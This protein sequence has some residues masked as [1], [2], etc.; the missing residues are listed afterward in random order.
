MHDLDGQAIH[1]LKVALPKVAQLPGA[2]DGAEVAPGLQDQ[3]PTR[4]AVPARLEE[5]WRVPGI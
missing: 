3:R 2:A 5:Q 4:R 1:P